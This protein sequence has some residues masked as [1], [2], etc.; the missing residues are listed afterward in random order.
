MKLGFHYHVPAINRNGQIWMPGYQSR[1]I[2][3]LADHVELLVCFLHLPKSGELYL[4]DS[5]LQAK[6]I[7]LV[8]L[9]PHDYLPS[10]ILRSR[11]LIEKIRPYEN[12][13]DVLLLRTPSPLA[14]IIAQSLDIPLS[15]LIVGDNTLGIND[16][17][18]PWWRKKIIHA[19][20]LWNRWQQIKHAAG[21]LTFVNSQINYDDLKSKISNLFMTKTTTLSQKDFF[22][23]DDTC[24]TRPCQILYAGRIE[25]A[26]GL[27]DILDAMRML[28]DEGED[29]CFDL[30]GWADEGDTSLSEL[31]AKAQTMNMADRVIY[32]GYKTVGPE[33]FDYYKQAD[34][35]VLA[36]QNSEGFPRTIWEAMAHSLPVVATR[37]GSIPDFIERA[38]ILVEPS[39]PIALAEGI[40]K[41]MFDDANRQAL[42]AAGR[43]LA[44]ENTLEKQSKKMIDIIENYL[45]TRR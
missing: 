32:H 29:I 10:R 30:V 44:Q 45:N 39:S 41:I 28:I 8:D 5:P 24:Q 34:M 7:E 15:F 16:L 42:I 40:K 27:L 4:M 17:P 1:F 21:V 31:L 20:W 14:P 6:N 18:Q 25:R 13:L 35:Y 19:F 2:D 33:L 43:K 38:A 12:T 23:R 3:S 22:E 11:S 9:G 26:K 37:V 36:S